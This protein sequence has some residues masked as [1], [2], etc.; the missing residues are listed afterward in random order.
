M[1][2]LER[3]V[4][5]VCLRKANSAADALRAVWKIELGE[6]L[7]NK[8]LGYVKDA[9]APISKSLEDLK[10]DPIIPRPFY[11]FEGFI[12]GKPSEEKKL[13]GWKRDVKEWEKYFIA[14]TN[15]YLMLFERYPLTE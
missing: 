3:D 5:L 10:E 11:D 15:E 2:N 12:K 4:R 14:L 7:T 13:G 9:L 1:S 6:E 8:D